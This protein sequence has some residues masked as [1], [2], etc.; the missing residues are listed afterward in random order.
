MTNLY[1]LWRRQ[2]R[3]QTLCFSAWDTFFSA[4]AT[5]GWASC[6]HDADL[7][8]PTLALRNLLL[9]GSGCLEFPKAIAGI[10]SL[11]KHV[12]QISCG[13]RVTSFEHGQLKGWQPHFQPTVAKSSISTSVRWFAAVSYHNWEKKHCVVTNLGDQNCVTKPSASLHETGFFL[14]LERR[15]GHDATKMQSRWCVLPLSGNCFW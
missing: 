9:V 15:D 6:K 5:K 13:Q 8:E 11:D 7:V 10:D 12:Q 1:N 2:L 14:Q 3:D 4:A